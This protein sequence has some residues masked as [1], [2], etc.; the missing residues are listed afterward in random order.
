MEIY[1]SQYAAFISV[2]RLEIM[3][4]V[5]MSAHAAKRKY[6]VKIKLQENQVS[7]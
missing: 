5:R 3:K 4:R 2:I 7:L 6:K 1:S